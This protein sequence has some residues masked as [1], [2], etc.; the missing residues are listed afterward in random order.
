MGVSLLGTTTARWSLLLFRHIYLS[1]YA[2]N[3][4]ASHG[5]GFSRFNT[6]L[7]G[8]MSQSGRLFIS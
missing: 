2:W 1:L 5:S 3:L 8:M 6:P 7:S 4:V